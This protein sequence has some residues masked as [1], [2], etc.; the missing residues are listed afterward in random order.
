MP[1]FSANSND[2]MIGNTSASSW[3]DARGNASTSG[4]IFLSNGTFNTFGIYNIYSGGRGGN[5][6]YCRRS[7]FQ[8]DLSGESET[9]ESA[10]LT[11]RLDATGVSSPG[12]TIVNSTGI[13]TSSSDF[14][15]CFSSGSIL[16]TEL[17]TAVSVSTTEGDHTFTFNA[18]GI[19]AINSAIGSGNLNLCLMGNDYDHDNSAP[20]LGGNYNKTTV[21]YQNHGTSTYRP[22]LSI[23]YAAAATDNSVFFGTNF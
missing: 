23:T 11:L 18:S 17:V 3:S 9:A 20:S 6:Y 8:F 12:V 1:N 13:P 14:G 5:T 15:M 4:N 16:G 19:S 2:C 22:K 21:Y 7:Y 10:T